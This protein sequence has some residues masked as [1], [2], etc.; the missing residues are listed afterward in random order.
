ML[1]VEVVELLQNH[2]GVDHAWIRIKNE[3]ISEIEVR[4]DF[5]HSRNEFD[6]P[7]VTEKVNRGDDDFQMKA[8]FP[9]S[10]WQDISKF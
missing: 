3:N 9:P 7:F 8:S 10:T 2:D 5:N 1:F 6:A 4:V